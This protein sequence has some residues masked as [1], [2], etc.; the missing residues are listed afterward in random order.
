MTTQQEQTPIYP[1]FIGFRADEVLHRRLLCFSRKLGR[2][3]SDVVRY[4]LVN[5]LNAYEGDND[6]IARMRREMY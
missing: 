1:W 4:L 6:A 3:K 5:C 2:R